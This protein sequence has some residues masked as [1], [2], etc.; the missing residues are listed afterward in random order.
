MSKLSRMCSAERLCNVSPVGLKV[1][2]RSEVILPRDGGE[3][4]FYDEYLYWSSASLRTTAVPSFQSGPTRALP[5]HYHAISP[6]QISKEKDIPSRQ[7]Q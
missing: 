1:E 5:L 6:V 4:P 3:K 2:Y 7:E